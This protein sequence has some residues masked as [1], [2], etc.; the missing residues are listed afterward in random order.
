MTLVQP[1]MEKIDASIHP[2]MQ[3]VMEQIGAAIQPSMQH[4]LPN[5]L[6]NLRGDAFK[7]LFRVNAHNRLEAYCKID[8]VQTDVLIN[9][10]MAQNRAVSFCFF[11]LNIDYKHA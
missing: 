6:P 8:G 1:V 9:G 10:L 11:A 7:S 2:S 3:P 4:Y 5:S